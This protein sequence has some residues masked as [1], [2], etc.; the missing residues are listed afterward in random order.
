M[1]CPDCGNE[2]SAEMIEM[3][4]CYVCGFNRFAEYE[5]KLKEEAERRRIEEEKERAAA[6]A[7]V[8]KA[9]HERWKAAHPDADG[10]Y[11]QYKTIVVKDK[12][13]GQVNAPEIERVL[14]EMGYDGWRLV[15]TFTNEVGKNAGAVGVG[16]M[17]LGLNATMDETVL[18][19]ERV[20]RV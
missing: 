3:G 18:V 7:L 8:K 2:I 9:E 20:V 19:F 1:K 16:D 14:N 17:V 4:L 11:Y 13:M 5:Q 6:E 15:S 12:F 10:K